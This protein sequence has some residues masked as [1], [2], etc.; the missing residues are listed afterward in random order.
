M[1]LAVEG[2][3]QLLILASP[4]LKQDRI[5]KAIVFQYNPHTSESLFDLSFFKKDAAQLAKK[6]LLRAHL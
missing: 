1:H 5:L 3:W 6:P 2:N 4:E